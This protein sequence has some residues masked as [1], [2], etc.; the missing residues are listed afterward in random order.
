[1]NKIDYKLDIIGEGVTYQP[2]SKVVNPM[3]S[4][5]NKIFEITADNSY[6]KTFILNLLAYALEADKL[7]D[8]KILSSIKDSIVR[9]DDSDSYGLEYE[10]SLE[11]PDNKE[12]SLSKKK[13]SNKIITV[14]GGPP[15]G[16]SY[17]HKDLSIIYDVPSNPGERLNAVIKDLGGWNN[18]LISKFKNLIQGFSQITR[19]FDNIRDEGKIKDLEKEIKKIDETKA[20]TF[21]AQQKEEKLLKTLI[22]CENL[23]ELKSLFINYYKADENIFKKTKELKSLKKPSSTP[24]KDKSKIRDLS[25][26]LADINKKFRDIISKLIKNVNSSAEI[27]K[28]INESGSALKYYEIIKKFDLENS[29]SSKDYV[30]LIG[31]FHDSLKYIK[32]TIIRFI[33]NE[34][35]GRNYLIHNSYQQLFKI[36]NQLI[37]KGIDDLLSKATR[38]QSE[39]LKNQLE[40]IIQNHK[41]KNYDEITSFVNNDLTSVRDLIGKYIRKAAE[42]KNENE[43]QSKSSGDSKY[44]TTEAELNSLKNSW[45]LLKNEFDILK[46][47]CAKDLD[48]KDLDRLN[49]LDKI[50]D[51]YQI[52]T[53]KV[54]DKN[55]L[56]DLKQSISKQTKIVNEKLDYIK[57]LQNNR[58]LKDISLKREKEKLP[59]TYDESQKDRIKSFLKILQMV[60]RNLG[61]YKEVIGNIENGDLMKFKNEND[62]DFIEL[63]G[64]IIAYSMD[65]KLLRADGV[66]S[67]L[68]FYDMIKQQF[69]CADGIVI[70]KADVST[71]LASANYLKQRIENI[72]GKYVVV[73]LDEIG[74]MA[75]NA[76]DKVVDSIKKLENN[77][78]LVLAIFTRPSSDGIQIIEY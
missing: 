65:N 30:S 44:Y 14:D 36:L 4:S 12:L 46:A 43:K 72:E 42:L 69:H 32:D 59:S 21:T 51:I 50:G 60:N 74:N 55:L 17:L 63:A 70:N 66:F 8:T 33:S 73:L 77:N 31:E 52:T 6:G 16:H 76:I 34:K 26:E 62:K 13:D 3:V 9:Y 41:V 64:K 20:K 48:I 28:E 71:G 47:N 11:L 45:R 7:D 27:F 67:K 53:T 29:L 25:K 57:E 38:V 56:E 54:K 5:K 75:Q 61:A 24:T 39:N 18:N 1:M 40:L 58:L 22:I 2:R 15:I 19:D 78:R 49:S 10:I 23:S 37:D 68:K 35:D